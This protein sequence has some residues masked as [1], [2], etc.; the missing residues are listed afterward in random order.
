[1]KG[2]TIQLITLL[3]ISLNIQAQNF[4]LAKKYGGIGADAAEKICADNNGNI[5]ITGTFENTAQFGNCSISS[6]GLTDIFIAK[7][8]SL[9]NCVWLKKGGSSANKDESNDIAIDS[10]GNVFITG[11]LRGTAI[12]DGISVT[13]DG[14]YI[15]KY[16]NNGAIQWVKRADGD[17]SNSIGIDSND[18][19]IITG[20]FSGSAFFG[21]TLLISSLGG[22]S[23]E[24]FVCKLNNNGSF[25]WT[26]KAI[27]A[28][29]MT[30]N[31]LTI[32][33]QNNIYITGAI[34]HTATFGST[35]LT[36]PLG[37]I[38][39]IFVTKLDSSGNY[40]WAN[41]AGGKLENFAYS[42]GLDAIGNIFISGYFDDTVHFNNVNIVSYGGRDIFVAKL[43]NSGNWLWA[44]HAGSTNYDESY[45]L[46]I[47]NSGNA[48]LTGYFQTQAIFGNTNI[49]TSSGAGDKTVFIASYANNGN[50]NWVTANKDTSNY[51]V[52]RG[53]GICAKNNTIYVTGWFAGTPKFGATYL[54]ANTMDAYVLKINNSLTGIQENMAS[55]SFSIFPNP[56][57]GLFEIKGLIPERQ[58]MKVIDVAGKQIV[59]QILESSNKIDLSNLKN[60]FYF[61]T[62]S[63]NNYISKQSLIICK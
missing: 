12:F 40:I 25:L 27:C 45:A 41:K 53:N 38:Y 34:E 36:L 29:S 39:N 3:F 60:G 16:N 35:T 15:A 20:I 24:M 51:Y 21:S 57:N 1:M 13:G 26:I 44:Q 43:D 59:N 61:M 46:T 2:T 31:D 37:E 33:S 10:H 4:T 55:T 56:S 23:S 54:T 52:L 14:I 17:Y 28:Y 62:I 11:K 47:D 42:I 30:A 5:Y 32:D 6:S 50:L 48:L 63:S 22:S 49:S 9:G 19:C 8:D 58:K 7:L 18:N